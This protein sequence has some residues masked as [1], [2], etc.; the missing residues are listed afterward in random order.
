MWLVRSVAV[1]LVLLVAGR[2][3]SAQPLDLERLAR[4]LNLTP[5]GARGWLDA[6]GV[7]PRRTA[8]EHLVA[9]TL[10][11]RI[12][13]RRGGS[14]AHVALGT[15]LDDQLRTPGV[16]LVLIH[17]HPHGVG[18]SADD[19]IQLGK[20]GVAAVVA[21]GHDGSVYVAAA[22]GRYDPD[23]FAQDQYKIVRAG[24]EDAVREALAL[25]TVSKDSVETQFAHL[26]SLALARAGVISYHAALSPDRRGGF[27]IGRIAY[28]RI[29]VLAASRVD[30]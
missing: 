9:V 19:L 10:D 5:P 2:D 14:V 21:V 25:R 15:E 17:N 18:F 13:A 11:G 3:A 28:G 30:R 27:E 7:V 24:V 23:F 1:A 6:L 4:D 22:G 16:R 26:V 29:V 20:P 12:V 8:E